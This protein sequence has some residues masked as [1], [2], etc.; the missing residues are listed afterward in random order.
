MYHVHMKRVTASQARREWFRLLDDA[1]AGEV[2][3][4]ERNGHRVELRLAESEA[5]AGS[6]S[7][8]Y[9]DVISA[10]DADQADRWTWEWDETGLRPRR[11]PPG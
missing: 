3:V 11:D 1:V 10:P 5:A 8:D 7:P 4:I 2:I 6:F 9:R